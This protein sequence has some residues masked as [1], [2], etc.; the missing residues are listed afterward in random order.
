M[1]DVIA[2]VLAGGRADAMGVLT[3]RRSMAAVPFGGL[4]RVIDFPLTNLSESGIDTVGILSQYRPASLMD[5]VG[6]GRP[7]DYNGR[8]RELTFLPPYE[9]TKELDW[10]RGTADAIF[11]NLH[12][13]RRHQPRDVLVVSGDHVYR[14]NYGPL[15][16]RHRRTK[17]DVTMAFKRMDV[18]RPSRFGIG[19]LGDGGRV[20]QYVEKPADPPSDL[21]SMT[22]YCFRTEVLMEAVRRNAE[23]GTTF[24]LYNE[25]IPSVVDGGRVFGYLHRGGW[26]Y[27]RPL[28]AWHDAHLR[29]LTRK[30]I[31]VPMDRLMTNVESG[32][33][34]DAPPAEFQASADVSRSLVA[35]GCRVAG[36]VRRSVL[37]PWVTVE[38]GAVV[39]DSVILNR[40][41]IRAGTRVIR[42]VLDKDVTVG[43]GALLCGEDRLVSVGKGAMNGEGSI[44]K[45]GAE[46]GPWEA[47]PMGAVIAQAAATG[48]RGGN[49]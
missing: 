32:G 1:K 42:S 12:I 14:M 3:S 24:H 27:L 13:L 20:T 30:G 19:V 49:R 36:K 38:E 29:L 40:T 48:P 37:S 41:T 28:P 25:V 4:Y 15:I 35:P 23:V 33:Y 46:V 7:W 11:Q 6:I 10:Y 34:G 9:G 43:E 8:D 16:D 47:V 22:V 44:L 18:G 5:H 17:A 45:A 26:E 39:E 2:L 31:G 21:A